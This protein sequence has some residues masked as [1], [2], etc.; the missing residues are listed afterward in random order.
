MLLTVKR[1]LL[2][3]CLAAFARDSICSEVRVWPIDVGS[4]VYVE[5]VVVRGVTCFSLAIAFLTHV[6]ICIITTLGTICG[7]I[8]SKYRNFN[9]GLTHNSIG[10]G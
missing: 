4:Q 3:L 8:V 2:Y 5:P 9:R 1:T 6:E 10:L 7:E